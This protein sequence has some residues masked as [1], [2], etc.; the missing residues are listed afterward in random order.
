VNLN[1]IDDVVAYIDDVAAYVDDGC[2][3]CCCFPMQF[4]DSYIIY[5]TFV[6]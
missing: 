4:V 1:Y 6:L 2:C 3:Y 5:I